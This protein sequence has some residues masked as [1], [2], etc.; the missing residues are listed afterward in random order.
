[1]LE[2]GCSLFVF[3]NDG[4][5]MEIALETAQGWEAVERT[6]VYDQMMDGYIASGSPANSREIGDQGPFKYRVIP[7]EGGDGA[8]FAGEFRERV[9]QALYDQGINAAVTVEA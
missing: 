9:Q 1:V 7:A 6:E 4:E 5:T 8:T 2:D 3:S